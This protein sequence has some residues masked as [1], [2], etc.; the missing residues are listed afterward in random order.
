M[1][2]PLTIFMRLNMTFKNENAI[3]KF[4]ENSQAQGYAQFDGPS[5]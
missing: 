5:P 4:P 1:M 3:G 2:S